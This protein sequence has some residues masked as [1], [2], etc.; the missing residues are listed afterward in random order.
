MS[1]R[2]YAMRT[3]HRLYQ[4]IANDNIC[5]YCGVPATALDHFVPISVVNGLARVGIMPHGRFLVPSCRECNSIAGAKCFNSVAAKRRYIQGQLRKKNKR[6]LA[7]PYWTDAQISRLGY[8][9][10]TTMRTS[11]VRKEWLEARLRWTNTA[12]KSAVNI[13]KIRSRW[14]AIGRGSVQDDAD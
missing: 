13:A 5:V 6:L 4:L 9:L 14:L 2:K 10:A 7:M 1:N 11:V 8:N 12:N 3:Y